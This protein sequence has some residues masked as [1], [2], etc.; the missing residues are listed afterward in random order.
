MGRLGW[1]VWQESPRR[2][3]GPQH[4]EGFRAVNGRPPEW[5]WGTHRRADGCYRDRGP[6]EPPEE[7][8][9][10]AVPCGSICTGRSPGLCGRHCKCRPV[11]ASLVLEVLLT[12]RGC[13][14]SLP[15]GPAIFKASSRVGLTHCPC[16]AVCLV[17]D[18][19]AQAERPSWL[20]QGSPTDASPPSLS[21]PSSG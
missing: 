4:V 11:R 18:P 15:H 7:V 17:S 14:H 8:A 13:S 5:E 12:T 9:V 6:P 10:S 21:L 2:K 20:A 1:G 3:D 19:Y 16:P